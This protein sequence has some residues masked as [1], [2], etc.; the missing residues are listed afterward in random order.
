[1]EDPT[2]PLLPSATPV[3]EYSKEDRDAVYKKIGLRLLPLAFLISL[4][5]F[6][7]RT[8]ISLGAIPMSADLKLSK[9]EFGTASSLFFVTYMLFQIPS[10]AALQKIGGPV[11]LG[12]LLIGWG[13]AASL[14]A[15]AQNATQLYVLRLILGMFEAGT[16]PGLTYYLAFFFPEDR[17]A[18]A[19][20]VANA[21]ITV[22]MGLSAQL[23]AAILE[24]DGVLNLQGWQWLFV[25]EGIP[26]LLIGAGSMM[27][28]PKSPSSV[29]FLTIRERQI[30][31]KDN[32]TTQQKSG[33]HRNFPYLVRTVILNWRLWLIVLTG[34]LFGTM[35]YT[36]MF[37]TPIWI[38]A[39]VN[40]GGL[41][42]TKASSSDPKG[43]QA[44]ILSAIPYGFSSVAVV[45]FGWTSGKLKDRKIHC[46]GL[47]VVGGGVFMLLPWLA[48]INIVLG[49]VALIIGHI[50]VNGTAGPWLSLAM[51][52]MTDEN[53]GFGLAWLNSIGNLSGLLGPMLTGIVADQTGS[54]K[55]AIWLVGGMLVFDGLVVA[56]MKDSVRDQPKRSKQVE[57]SDA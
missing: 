32:C 54:Y 19:I 24:M 42:W 36:T 49:F 33:M 23:G 7:D 14:T 8:N 47:W 11:W 48:D 56:F 12:T 46:M 1:M 53:K 39:M 5:C 26:A 51:S 17:L 35:M 27:F 2:A 34:F 55:A 18:W 38:D 43:V 28:L 21:G 44:A 37:W 30:L 15:F 50:G 6:V 25:L 41:N 22:G 10:N 20:G 31:K 52:F 57:I 45:L 13:I 9:S 40:G 4:V 3:A 16:F 29:G